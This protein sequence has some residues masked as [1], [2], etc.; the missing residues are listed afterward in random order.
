MDNIHQ[1]INEE[2]AKTYFQVDISTHA[3]SKGMW[4]GSFAKSVNEEFLLEEGKFSKRNISYPQALYKGIDEILVNAIDQWIK[5][6]GGPKKYMVTKI[7]IKFTPD[8]YISIFNNGDGIPVDLV[9]NIKGES[10]YVP[11]LIS[12]EFLAGSNNSDDKNRISGGTNGLG[13]KLTSNNSKHF[14][15][16]TVDIVRKKHYIQESHDRL[17]RTD[18]PTITPLKSLGVDSILK[19]GGALFKFLPD[20][21]I[22]KV[23]IKKDYAELNLLFKTRAIHTAAHTGLCVTYNDEEIKVNNMETFAELFLPT[24][25]LVCTKIKHPEYDWDVVVGISDTGSYET[26]S[27]VNGICVKTGTHLNYIRDLVIDGIKL[28][29]ERLLKKFVVYKKS[30]LQNNLFIMISG[31]IPNPAFDSQ[32][33]TNIAGSV[34]SYK[35]YVLGKSVLA[36]IWK[37][38][39]VRLVEQY[40]TDFKT[41]TTRK[42]NTNGIKKYKKAKYAA[43]NKSDQC[44]L[45]ICEGDSAESMTRTSLTSKKVPMSYDYYGTF[46]IGGVPMNSRTKSTA[47]ESSGKTVVRRQKQLVDNE[48]LSSLEKVCNLNHTFTYETKEERDTLSYGFVVATVD[49]DLDGVGQI[50]G[51]ILSHFER[52]WPALIMHGY[53]KQLATPIIRAFPKSGKAAVESFYTDEEYRQW[54]LNKFGK[55]ER[56]ADDLGSGE[57]GLDKWEVK[58]YKG[59][60][61]HNDDEAIHMFQKYDSSLYTITYDDLAAK[62]FE[63]Y[64][65]NDPDLRKIELVIRRPPVVIHDMSLS[66][67]EHLQSHT[68]EFQLDNIMRKLP[69]MYD[70]LN[71]ARRK[72]LCGS[73]NR[74]LSNNGEVKVFQLAGYIAEKMNYHHGSASLEKT[75]INMAQDY[76]GA[77]NLPLLLPLSQFGCI[78][79]DTPVLMWDSTIKKAKNVLAGDKL[80][81]DDGLVRNVLRTINGEDMMFKIS[82]GNMENYIVNNNHILTLCFS[83]HKTIRWKDSSK[84]WLMNYLDIN[85]KTIKSKRKGT[86][87]I[88]DS[89]H[90]NKSKLSKDDALLMMKEFADS[91]PDTSIIDINIQE[92]LKLP[93]SVKR[94]LKGVL[95]QSVIN[96]PEHKVDIDPYILGSWLGDGMSDCHAFA[97][98]DSEII[99]SWSIWLDSIGCEVK[100]CENYNDH[101]GCTY[102]IRRRGSH[103]AF[104]DYALGDANHTSVE[105]KGCQTSN[106]KSE[107][108]DWVFDKKTDTVECHGF[109]SNGYRTKNLN[110]FK[111]IMKKNNL[112][113]N[114]HIPVAYVRNSEETRLQILAGMIDTDGSLKK[115]KNQYRFEIYQCTER[116]H[117]LESFRIIAGSL[118]YR[119]KIFKQ[120]KNMLTLS[121]TGYGLEK[122]PTRLPRKQ[123][124][125]PITYTMNSMVHSIK[126]TPIGKGKFCGWSVDKNERFLLGDFTITHNSR[127]RSGHDYGAPRYIKTK[128]NKDLVSALFRTEDDYVLDYTYDEGVCNEPVCYVPVAPFALLESLEIPA[129]GW[130]YAGYARDWK[131]VHKNILGL[132]KGYDSETKLQAFTPITMPFWKNKWNGTTRSVNSKTGK[133]TWSMG[134]YMYDDEK[135]V[136]EIFELPFQEGNESYVEK[137][138]SKTYVASVQ[139]DS[140]KLQID[141]KIKL[142][143]L[144]FDGIV[145]TCGNK[146]SPEFDVIEDYCLLKKRMNKHLNV[147]KDGIVHEAKSYKEIL[148]LWFVKRHDTYVRRFER[149]RIIIRLRIMFHKQVSE[150]VENHKK[151]NFSELDEDTAT[152]LLTKDKYLKFNKALLDNPQFTPLDKMEFLV[153]DAKAANTSYNYL[154]AVGP[155]QRMETARIARAKKLKELEKYYKHIMSDDIVKTTWL[156][157]LKEL[158][159]VITKGT[160]SELGWLCSERK[161]KFK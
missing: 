5:T 10:M 151:Y 71:P 68:K 55:D 150:F 28:R 124:K 23:D 48:R 90:F 27:I 50:F 30:M 121:I 100:H 89:K 102:Y 54:V 47:Y 14:V 149:L 60:A 158:D 38:M 94:N 132:V 62:T 15:L 122:I 83:E 1:K 123:I 156:E 63:I 73:R 33:K 97:S 52:F 61:T 64:Y 75:I 88:S 112:F 147:I 134:P 135:N 74:F 51:L 141:I 42:A 69:H 40:L 49:Q 8:G 111:E 19:K 157:E 41:K 59:L 95:N 4:S 12:T 80:V 85:T 139:D 31:N 70:G 152:S 106:H 29:T 25:Q 144:G 86:S 110:P 133:Q 35:E 91:I 24:S 128:L 116:K 67:T 114:K 13:I 84:C 32:S 145:T 26:L 6:L 22:Y 105:C 3:K 16:E 98:I 92:Y 148:M 126:V 82:N 37:M 20:Y 108:C 39:E 81:G 161:V 119:A 154:F 136:I 79:P 99:K 21:K 76:V 43:T 159:D 104:D 142:K 127:F 46:N 120:Q 131:A 107:A 113:K 117:L 34:A 160:T 44:T 118:G 143:P 78:D 137:M 36:K 66:C 2:L 138:E 87:L 93:S 72:I 115:T 65:G 153:C 57:S 109:R 77:N 18:P 129:T 96:W 146:G 17:A 155:R 56:S 103:R 53:V 130:K 101:E 140:S 11:Q 45:L 7:V 125:T 58:Y 9:K